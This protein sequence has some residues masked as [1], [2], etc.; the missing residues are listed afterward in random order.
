MDIPEN[1]PQ[2]MTV[3]GSICLIHFFVVLDSVT[4]KHSQRAR[5]VT[6]KRSIWSF[7]ASRWS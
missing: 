2:E 4:A 3:S 7:K 1:Y 5:V 6:Y